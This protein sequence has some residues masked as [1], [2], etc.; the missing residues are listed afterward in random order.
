MLALN[1][2]GGGV[3]IGATVNIVNL[4]GDISSTTGDLVSD[5]QADL[6]EYNEVVKEFEISADSGKTSAVIESNDITAA[7]INLS[8]KQDNDIA[9]ESGGF[10][11]GSAAIGVGVGVMLFQLN[12]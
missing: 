9:L 4:G 1:I 12:A 7:S 6:D 5:E 3:A 8:S 11:V 2:S 10:A